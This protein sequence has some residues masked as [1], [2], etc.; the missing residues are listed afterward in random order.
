M[1]WVLL[2]STLGC[3][4]TTELG[5]F[6]AAPPQGVTI[7]S[8]EVPLDACPVAGEPC[9][10]DYLAL[11]SVAPAEVLQPISGEELEEQLDTVRR[12]EWMTVGEDLSPEELA[13]RLIEAANIGWMLE[14][15]E[16]ASMRVTIYD[17]SD[18]AGDRYRR[19]IL[20]DEHVGQIAGVTL[21]PDG[22]GPHPALVV[23][24][25]HDQ[26][27]DIW[28]GTYGGRALADRGFAVIAPTSRVSA[29]D[30]YESAVTRTLLL[31]G[32]T[33]AGV[34]SYEQLLGLKYAAS[35]G[36]VDACRIG[37]IGH[38]GGSVIGNITS[39][40]GLGFVAY[41]TDLT[42]EYHQELPGEILLDESSPALHALSN[43]INQFE[44][45]HIAVLRTGYEYQSET[46]PVE[47]HW[48][49]VLTF[50]DEQVRDYVP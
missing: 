13:P 14:G 6:C 43:E 2:I 20:E 15:Y 41:V 12:Q 32:L 10:E 50:L 39:R 4:G 47:D 29:A 16:T 17:S 49:D 26:T 21:L 25:G 7:A 44:D 30:R 33:F 48:P 24:H 22:D 3:R 36:E 42:S 46:L 34:R 37:L 8:A 23:A 9:M 28:L 38:S 31:N 40:L 27:A 45:S 19:W 5:D 1:G 35:M 18:R 11:P